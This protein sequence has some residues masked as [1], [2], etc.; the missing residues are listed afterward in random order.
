M[1]VCVCCAYRPFNSKVWFGSQNYVHHCVSSTSH[2]YFVRP[3]F[4]RAL[5]SFLF[6]SPDVSRSVCVY[7]CVM[8]VKRIN[9]ATEKRQMHGKTLCCCCRRRCHCCYS[10]I[11]V[12]T[13]FGLCSFWDL[14]TLLLIASA[15]VS[16]WLSLFP[17]PPPASTCTHVWNN[18]KMKR[19][20]Q[21]KR[22]E[23]L[24]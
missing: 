3:F 14:I 20:V 11:F 9:Y 24:I 18:A 8:N 5:N 2:T 12:E 4:F 23:H 19:F 10:A 13:L 1:W 15:F 7:E 22:C 21:V 16:C 6:L 17:P